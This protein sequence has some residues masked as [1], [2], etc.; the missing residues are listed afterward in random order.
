MGSNLL[1]N[2]SRKR[3]GEI[4]HRFDTAGLNSNRPCSDLPSYRFAA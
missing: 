3:L 2:A 4:M 1:Q